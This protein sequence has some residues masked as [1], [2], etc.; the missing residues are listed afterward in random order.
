M[1]TLIAGEPEIVGTYKSVMRHPNVCFELF[2]F[3]VMLDENLKVR[4][5]P[6][7]DLLEGFATRLT[8]VASCHFICRA[9]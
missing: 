7:I 8:S 9:G 2:G 5:V 1:K 3:D 4:G 6:L